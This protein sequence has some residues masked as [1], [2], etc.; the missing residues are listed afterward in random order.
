M[1]ANQS[2][3]ATSLSMHVCMYVHKIC[4]KQAKKEREREREVESGY[5]CRRA[6]ACVCVFVCVC[7]CMCVCACVF[8]RLCVFEPGIDGLI[9]GIS[10]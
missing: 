2:F 6:R 8:V 9:R 7:A 5:V 3:I 1:L 4:V 10:S